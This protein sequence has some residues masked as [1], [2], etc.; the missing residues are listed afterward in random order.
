M[1]EALGATLFIRERL[2]GPSDPAGRT[3]D[4][5]ALRALI[6]ERVYAG[7]P[8]AQDGATQKK[9]VY[10]LIVT[11]IRVATD[12]LV[13]DGA[14]A[15]VSIVVDTKVI[16]TGSYADMSP[17]D[18]LVHRLLQKAHGP[19]GDLDVMGCHREQTL[20]LTQVDDDTTYRS[21]VQSFRVRIS[22]TA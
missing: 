1:N 3:A 21:L 5:N 10:P 15:F 13:V 12:K 22:Q 11:T 18:T 7:V 8:P 4:Q 16:G 19:V 17:I 9:P 20:L 6:G 14:S 2:L